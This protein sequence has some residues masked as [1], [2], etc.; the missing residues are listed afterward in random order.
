MKKI[1]IC[2]LLS[3]A[4]L[5][6]TQN[7]LTVTSWNVLGYPEK[8]IAGREWFTKKLLELNT[9]VICIQE[10]GNDKDCENFIK[11]E[12]GFYKGHFSNS[13]DPQDNAIFTNNTINIVGYKDPEGFRHPPKLAYID[14]DGFNFLLLTIHLSYD[15]KRVRE[16]EIKLLKDIVEWMSSIDPDYMIVGDFNI[17]GDEIV[18]LATSLGMMLLKPVNQNNQ[19][20]TYSKDNN[21]YD[22]F[23][24]SKDI[25]TE[26]YIDF[27]INNVIPEDEFIARSVS[28]HISITA[29]FRTDLLFKDD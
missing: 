8:S 16:N 15:D 26:E 22:H 4:S 19:G 28:D 12:S 2:I 11:N 17:Q 13:S 25:Y 9:N 14:K 5:T 27:K 3:V 7:V 23:L 1:C 21:R 24:V 20:T 18:D 10:I 29:T 6:F